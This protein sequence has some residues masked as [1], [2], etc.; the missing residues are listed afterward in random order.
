MQLETYFE[1][2]GR[3]WMRIPA[4]RKDRY[5]VGLDI[6]QVNDPTA[7]AIVRHT[8]EPLETWSER[9]V[10]PNANRYNIL[11]QDMHE[12]FDLQHLERLPLG[13]LFPDQV[14]AVVQRLHTRPLDPTVEVI[15]DITGVGSPI[16]DMLDR[17]N[18]KVVRV[19][20]TAGHEPVHH[21]KQRWSVP[22]HT[23]VTGL[24]ASFQCKRLRVAPAMKEVRAL[25]DE[26]ADF[27]PRYTAAGHITYN[28]REGANDD[29][30]LALALALFGHTRPKPN[31]TQMWTG[32]PGTF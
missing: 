29:M 32:I 16:A 25:F 31:K 14:A 15:T 21:G 2:E 9:R 3:Q 6:G 12:Y 22:K 8:I 1:H 27:I 30:I 7:L 18:L 4:V 26:L 10:A 28:A 19:F 5:V 13:M 17:A 20:I 11:R 24:L 23:L